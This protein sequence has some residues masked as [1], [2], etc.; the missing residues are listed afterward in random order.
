MTYANNLFEIYLTR[1]RRNSE[2]IV[3]KVVFEAPPIEE[4]P[5]YQVAVSNVTT[6][7][8]DK[9]RKSFVLLKNGSNEI[10][11]VFPLSNV[12]VDTPENSNRMPLALSL[13][14]LKTYLENKMGAENISRAL[15]PIVDDS[16]NEQAIEFDFTSSQPTVKLIGS[17]LVSNVT[18]IVRFIERLWPGIQFELLRHDKS[19]SDSPYF[20]QNSNITQPLLDTSSI[21]VIGRISNP[22]RSFHNSVKNYS[23]GDAPINKEPPITVSLESNGA[24]ISA[25]MQSKAPTIPKAKSDGWGIFRGIALIISGIGFLIA[26]ISSLIGTLGVATPFS[27]MMMV[28]GIAIIGSGIA[29]IAIASTRTPVRIGEEEITMSKRSASVPHATAETQPLI[30]GNKPAHEATCSNQ[31]ATPSGSGFFATR[32]TQK[33]E[34]EDSSPPYQNQDYNSLRL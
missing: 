22:S 14:A 8:L 34:A 13:M 26:G 20:T 9:I 18:N 31:S 16:G 23:L 12:G 10:R 6:M 27:V 28:A 32:P 21:S 33:N 3:G 11:A 30:G 2:N 4:N 15:I 17:R 19:R 1:Q 7:E 25:F 5:Y 29:T 24:K